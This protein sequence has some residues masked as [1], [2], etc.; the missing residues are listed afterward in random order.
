[1]N[2]DSSGLVFVEA[3]TVLYN[4][5]LNVGKNKH[6]PTQNLANMVSMAHTQFL[7]IIRTLYLCKGIASSI[8]AQSLKYTTHQRQI[9]LNSK[10]SAVLFI[11][12]H[13]DYKIWMFKMA[14]AKFGNWTQSWTTSIHLL[15]S[16]LTSLSLSLILSSILYLTSF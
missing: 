9:I 12:R 4:K 2:S 8:C 7:H 15:S 1:L 5:S 10:F 13:S 16:Q 6:H 3:H 14:T 11:L